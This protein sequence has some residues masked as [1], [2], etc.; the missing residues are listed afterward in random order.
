M[1]PNAVVPSTIVI[2]D[3]LAQIQFFSADGGF[4]AA[5]AS[6]QS[7]TAVGIP[8]GSQ[9]YPAG[10]TA[11]TNLS[12]AGGYTFPQVVQVLINYGL[13]AGTSTLGTN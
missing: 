13:L 6:Q 3:S 2:G 7:T 1:T 11:L 10:G 5:Y 12:S 8:L 4:G 9:S